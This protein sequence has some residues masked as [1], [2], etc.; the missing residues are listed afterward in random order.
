M[1]AGNDVQYPLHLLSL[2]SVRDLDAKIDKD[3][4]LRVLDPG[5]FRAN[6][7]GEL[8]RL[9]FERGRM[10][11]ACPTYTRPPPCLLRHLYLHRG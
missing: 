10:A 2:S 8:S 1:D 9:D 7:I 5:R 11:P 3:E 4:G 6:M